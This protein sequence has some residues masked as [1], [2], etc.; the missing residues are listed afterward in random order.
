MVCLWGCNFPG[1]LLEEGNEMDTNKNAGANFVSVPL[2]RIIQ[3]LILKR[4]QAVK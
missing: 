1:R 4:C 2:H 3:L